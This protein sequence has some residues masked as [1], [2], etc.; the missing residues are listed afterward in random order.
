MSEPVSVRSAQHSWVWVWKLKFAVARSKVV[1]GLHWSLNET[2]HS[3]PK[4]CISQT[5]AIY[6]I[7]RHYRKI[8]RL[9]TS[10]LSPLSII[11]WNHLKRW[12]IFCH[13]ERIRLSVI[14]LVIWNSWY[15]QHYLNKWSFEISFKASMTSSV[16]SSMCKWQLKRSDYCGCS[17]KSITP[18]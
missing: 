13:S 1:V 17:I 8:T 2:A 10:A 15:S 12:C 11:E 14:S 18:F 7:L 6:E 9:D 16:A 4:W 3:R 5:Y